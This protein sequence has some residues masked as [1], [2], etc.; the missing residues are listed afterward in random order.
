[1]KAANIR[2][3]T[4]LKNR[5]K[6]LVQEI[7]DGGETMVITQNGKPRVVVMD[8][9]QHDRLQ[10]SL[11]MLKLLAHGQDQ[12][13]RGGRTFTSAEVRTRAR[14]ALARARMP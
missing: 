8:V 4:D 5:T 2:P 13:V 3:I 9:K 6:E 1:M 7:V 12:H 10:D 11:A 14:A